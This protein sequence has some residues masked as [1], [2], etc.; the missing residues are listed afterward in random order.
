MRTGGVASH[1]ETTL[2]AI[3]VRTS[4]AP[5]DQYVALPASMRTTGLKP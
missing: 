1:G 2:P 5:A 3:I 4:L